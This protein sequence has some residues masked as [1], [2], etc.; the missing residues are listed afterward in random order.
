MAHYQF[1][2]FQKVNASLNE[3]WDF[4]SAP[5]NLKDITPDYM[6]FDIR[7]KNLPSKMYAGMLIAYKVSPLM[8]IK[9]NWLTEI[10]QVKEKEFFIDEQKA[11]PYKLWHHQHHLIP[12]KNGVLMKDIVTYIPPFGF[13]G[14]IANQWII[15]RKLKEIFDY[16]EA[17]IVKIFGEYRPLPEFIKNVG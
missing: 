4:I 3:L 11:G 15:K 7:S 1:I 13:L 8:G 5:Q 6:G 16:R 17:K 12:I 2:R 10:T 14:S 9:L